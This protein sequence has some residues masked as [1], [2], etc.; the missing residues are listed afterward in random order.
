[1]KRA[2]TQF[3]AAGL[4]LA[5]YTSWVF[6]DTSLKIAGTSA[7][8]AYEVIAFVGLAEVLLL[9]L[10]EVA[11]GG[12]RNLLPHKVGPQLMRSCLDLANTVCVVIALRHLPLALFYILVFFAPMV[13]TLLSA[14][15]LNER[16]VWRKSLAILTGFLGVVIAVNPLGIRGTGDWAGYLACMVC[17]AAFSISM[18]WS[19]VLTQTELPQSLTFTSGATMM[20]AGGA[21]MLHHAVPLSLRL[22]LVLGATG[23][24]CIAGSMCFFLALKHAPAATVSQ[25][26]YSQLLTGSLLAYL[27][28]RETLTIPMMCGAVLII[29]AGIYTAAVSYGERDAAAPLG[30]ALLEE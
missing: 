5:G 20:F 25:F 3:G 10:F 19:R 28:W 22:G 17:V 23:F 15:F 18:V 12:F 1:M 26:H 8:P 13:T 24:F 27:L 7:L 14:V 6:A 11:R 2:T 29:A 21:G 9:L 30:V 16:L 4:A